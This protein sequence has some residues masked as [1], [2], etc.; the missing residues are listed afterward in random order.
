MLVVNGEGRVEARP[1]KTGDRI[2][3]GVVVLDGLTEGETLVVE[4]IQ[5]VRPGAEVQTAFRTPAE[6]PEIIDQEASPEAAPGAPEDTP[7]DASG[8]K[9]DSDP[10]AEP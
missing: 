10:Q 9:Q 4:G 5:K 7:G 1:V 6:E 3:D 8:G 2:E